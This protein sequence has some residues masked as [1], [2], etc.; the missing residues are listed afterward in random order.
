MH[1]VRVDKELRV[2]DILIYSVYNDNQFL[3]AAGLPIKSQN[4][5][6][7]LQKKGIDFVYIKDNPLDDA[8]ISNALNAADREFDSSI[9]NV[10]Q[11]LMKAGSGKDGAINLDRILTDASKLVDNFFEN[12]RA[13][14]K[15]DG[16]EGNSKTIYSHSLATAEYALTLA[17]VV[18][19]YRMQNHF[20]SKL[21][22]TLKDFYTTVTVASLL[23]NIGE[24]CKNDQSML[25][26]A[27][28]GF[29]SNVIQKLVEKK[30]DAI[31]RDPKALG[32]LID[33]NID[34]R[35]EV[36]FRKVITAIVDGWFTK[37]IDDDEV[38]NV[39]SKMPLYSY[40]LIKASE[41]RG[42]SKAVQ[43]LN[44]AEAAILHQN[45]KLDHSNSFIDMPYLNEYKKDN[46]P[47]VISQIIKIAADYDKK[48]KDSEVELVNPEKIINEMLE[49]KEYNNTYLDLF[50]ENIP[51]YEVGDIVTLNTGVDAMVV[52]FTADDV[53]RPE[54]AITNPSTGKPV[55]IDLRRKEY[56]N[57]EIFGKK[58]PAIN[59]N[60]KAV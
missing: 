30:E 38:K 23:H 55:L 20:D 8:I 31:K 15:I 42:L 12:K 45:D 49:S 40:G 46:D 51:P 2:G 34:I 33:K 35:N 3:Q 29:S 48:I 56:S 11:T 14:Y 6:D 52:S 16:E 13:I 18:E 5:I 25:S 53:K 54:I 7:K 37:Y 58:T 44:S 19:K 39:K 47:T 21:D 10:H 57:F 59:I 32:Q 41:D 43:N 28:S 17:R 27:R 50:K 24:L 60:E 1:A 36:L 26:V 22:S 9:E 4:I